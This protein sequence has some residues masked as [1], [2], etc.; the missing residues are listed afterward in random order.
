MQL[1]NSISDYTESEFIDF[2]NEIYRENASETD[3]KLDVL[4][5]HFEK[6]TEHPDGTDLIY[7]AKSDSDST[8]IAITKIIKEWRAKNG[9]PGFKKG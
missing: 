7:Y 2:M 5:N 3:D 1:K 4:L 6:I 9:K 8:P